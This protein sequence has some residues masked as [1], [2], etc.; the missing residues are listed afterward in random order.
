MTPF[1]M[2]SPENSSV[3]RKK[4]DQWLP[5]LGNGSVD[6]RWAQG[7]FCVDGKG[8]KLECG[9]GYTTLH[10]YQKKIFELYPYKGRIS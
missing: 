7:K 5:W 1:A 10:I 6:H 4:T 2:K 9:D 3:L 8:P